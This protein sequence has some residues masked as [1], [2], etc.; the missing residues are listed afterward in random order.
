MGAIE[1][2]DPRIAALQ[3]LRTQ[4]EAQHQATLA[5]LEQAEGIVQAAQAHAPIWL[6]RRQAA[7]YLGCSLRTVDALLADGRLSHKAI[8]A[9]VLIARADLDLLDT[10]R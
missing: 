6:S 8:G 10:R 7:E 2:H 5:A 3:R 9:R 4:V 1:H